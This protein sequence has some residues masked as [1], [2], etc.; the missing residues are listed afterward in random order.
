MPLLKRSSRPLKRNKSGGIRG[1][2]AGRLRLLSSN[3][4]MGFTI[5]APLGISLCDTLPGSGRHSALSWKS[6]VAFERM[7]A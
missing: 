6:P 2:P 4:L 5:H 3:T 7:V 1:T